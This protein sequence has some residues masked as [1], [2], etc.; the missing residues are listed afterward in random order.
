MEKEES[1]KEEREITYREVISFLE[2]EMA[3]K[4]EI[5]RSPETKED[6]RKDAEADHSRLTTI[7]DLLRRMT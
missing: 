7:I 2:E 5:A 4:L 1:K 3:E 6:K